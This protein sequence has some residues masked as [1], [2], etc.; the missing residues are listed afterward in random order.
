MEE[1]NALMDA[2]AQVEAA[3]RAESAADAGAADAEAAA[4]EEAAADAE[5]VAGADAEA[6][7]TAGA[8][9]A[10]AGPRDPG[11]A[12]LVSQGRLICVAATAAL[13]KTA[14][15]RNFNEDGQYSPETPPGAYSP[16]AP[17]YSSD[18][19]M[20]T[21][22]D[23]EV[24]AAAADITELAEDEAGGP[25]ERGRT[26]HA[27]VHRTRSG[28][29]SAG[30]DSRQATSRMQKKRR[31]QDDEL[32][33]HIHQEKL[34]ELEQ[35]ATTEELHCVQRRYHQQRGVVP[36]GD[37]DEYVQETAAPRGGDDMAD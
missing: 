14:D 15:A 34:E 19:A 25:A 32:K 21:R 8:E 1:D 12:E 26:T 37:R 33:E 13:K 11:A 27:A 9:A 2:A 23:P 6:I 20:S 10:A 3:A 31:I 17:S 22:Q 5:A 16:V 36:A 7:G 24:R 35:T 29:G 30:A 18:A 28:A 4:Q